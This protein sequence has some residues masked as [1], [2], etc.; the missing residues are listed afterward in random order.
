MLVMEASKEV[1][2]DARDAV[3]RHMAACTNGT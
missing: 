3:L 2:K 1:S